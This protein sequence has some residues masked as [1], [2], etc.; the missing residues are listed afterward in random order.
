MRP[1]VKRSHMRLVHHP[2]CGLHHGKEC[3]AQQLERLERNERIERKSEQLKR[4]DAKREVELEGTFTNH[5][6]DA[7]RSS[8]PTE[9]QQAVDK[10]TEAYEDALDE[11]L[12]EMLDKRFAAQDG[13]EPRSSPDSS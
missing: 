7:I 3:N 1:Y 13:S 2:S 11:V 6:A 9:R 10:A 4:L 12:Y 8:G 5:L